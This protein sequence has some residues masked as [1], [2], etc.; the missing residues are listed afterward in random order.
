MKYYSELN[1]RIP[2]NDLLRNQGLEFEVRIGLRAEV[3]KVFV[4]RLTSPLIVDV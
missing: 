3:F 4:L 1:I 2:A